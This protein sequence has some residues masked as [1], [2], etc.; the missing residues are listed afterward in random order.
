MKWNYCLARVS[1]LFFLHFF[2]KESETKL[3]LDDIVIHNTIQ[4]TFFELPAFITI[5]WRA[6]KLGNH[7]FLVVGI[8]MYVCVSGVAQR[9][10]SLI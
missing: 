2:S 10:N 5:F 6:L 9:I 1:L 4:L 7:Y 3:L 8:I